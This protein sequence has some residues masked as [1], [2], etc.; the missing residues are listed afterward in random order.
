M[1]LP[2][3]K[4]GS[5]IPIIQNR[6]YDGFSI[7][8]DGRLYE[9]KGIRRK[10][11]T[12]QASIKLLNPE[13][14]REFTDHINNLNSATRRD[15]YIRIAS[16]ETKTSLKNIRSDFVIVSR[17]IESYKF[18]SKPN[19]DSTK[20]EEVEEKKKLE[21]EAREFGSSP[22]LMERI[23]QDYEKIGVVGEKIAC[24][25]SYLTMT[26]R[27]LNVPLNLLIIASSGSGKSHIQNS[28]LKF[29]PPKELVNLS[30]ITPRALFYREEP[31]KHKVIA[32]EELAGLG[33]TYSIRSLITMGRLSVEFVCKEQNSGQLKTE[34][35][36][37]EGP[38]SLMITTT[39]ADVEPEM[40][41]RFFV[42]STDETTEQTEK[43]I[44]ALANR[45]SLKEI[46]SRKEI[47]H[48]IRKHQAFQGLLRRIEVFNRYAGNLSF[49][50]TKLEFRRL[51]QKYIQLITAIAF[52]H[53][54]SREIKTHDGIE[55]VEVEL[56]D[57]ALANKLLIESTSKSVKDELSSPARELLAMLR[58]MVV[59]PLS[60]EDFPGGKFTRKN[61]REATGYSNYRTHLCVKELLKLDY[62]TYRGRLENG[63]H[64]YSLVSEDGTPEEDNILGVK[65]VKDIEA[66]FNAKNNPQPSAINVL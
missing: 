32:I 23:L 63:Q 66:E 2:N 40:L 16:K 37:L 45:N 29:C 26:S 5:L 33:D 51:C 22:D 44:N 14:K 38:S 50:S 54:L 42:T 27:N 53:Q 36:E 62:I 49:S 55:Y 56:C 43:I 65:S 8:L 17:A 15:K 60:K 39:K 28:T 6:T 12:I 13:S 46:T 48:I 3:L 58:E 34:I 30:S 18:N 7:E 35:R 64:S 10:F 52:L 1:N 31:I 25:L 24:Q 41:S 21:E 47:E 57:I 59:N 20:Q 9:I 11:G 4:L 19:L 61:I